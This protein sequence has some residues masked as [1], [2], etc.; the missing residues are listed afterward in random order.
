MPRRVSEGQ[1]VSR[2]G[3]Q[4]VTTNVQDT[5]GSL[6]SGLAASYRYVALPDKLRK[7]RQCG[8]RRRRQW[9][10]PVINAG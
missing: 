7:L 8:L 5:I 2:M 4:K 6:A 10:P 1:T 3:C 9:H